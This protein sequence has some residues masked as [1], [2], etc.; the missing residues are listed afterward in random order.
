[1]PQPKTHAVIF[2]KLE[3]LHHSSIKNV[4]AWSGETVAVST[5]HWELAEILF[6]H[7]AKIKIEKP[8][9]RTPSVA[10][11]WFRLLTEPS[12]NID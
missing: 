3:R 12:Q 11:L 5:K 8:H 4:D 7:Q 6:D 9:Y 1:M 10:V 2:T